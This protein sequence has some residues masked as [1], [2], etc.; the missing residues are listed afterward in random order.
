MKTCRFCAEEVQDEAVVCRHC[1]KSAVSTE[2][3]DLG[4]RWANMK[5]ELRDAE[6][7]ALSELDQAQLR[8]FLELRRKKVSPAVWVFL[9]VVVLVVLLQVCAEISAIGG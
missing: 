1:G 3:E 2:I 8:G 5:Q 4:R 7:A 9:A 6:W